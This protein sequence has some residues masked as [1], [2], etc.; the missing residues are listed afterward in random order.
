[1][2]L[3]LR[4]AARASSI[5]VPVG[6]GLAYCWDGL[7]T[8]LASDDYAGRFWIGL[9][10]WF[11]AMNA[12]SGLGTLSEMS[13]LQRRPVAQVAPII[14]ALT[15]AVPVALAPLVAN[16]S[17]P[18]AGWTDAGLVAGLLLVVGGALAL[19]RSPVVAVGLAATASSS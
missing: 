17:W 9:A 15:T 5:V 8:K 11:L 18:A 6:A 10:F 13:A 14:L 3:F 4:G 2:P 16:E 1:A 12:A 7:A 19:T